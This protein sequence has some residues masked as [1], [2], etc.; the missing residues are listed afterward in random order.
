MKDG[1]HM[2]K[3]MQK[4]VIKYSEGEQTDDAKDNQHR[5]PNIPRTSSAL[6]GFYKCKYA[7][8]EN[9]T[10]YQTPKAHLKF[11]ITDSMY[12]N[13]IIGWKRKMLSEEL[14][15]SSKRHQIKVAKNNFVV[16]RAKF[17]QSDK[18]V[19]INK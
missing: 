10:K 9:S 3:C 5:L 8:M 6:T 19:F 15:G 18:I 12:D 17:G 13:I 16:S 7:N 2:T 4:C 11:K 1:T 14:S